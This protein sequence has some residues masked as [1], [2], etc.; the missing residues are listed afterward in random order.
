MATRRSRGA[1]PD[2]IP[3]D[4]SPLTKT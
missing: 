2:K 4:D 1:R 3:L